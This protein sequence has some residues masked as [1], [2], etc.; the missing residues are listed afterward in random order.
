MS[1]E[2]S[3]SSG[4]IELKAFAAYQQAAFRRHDAELWL[5]HIG[6][7]GR[8]SDTLRVS[9]AHCTVKLVVAGQYTTGGTNY[10]D[11][12]EPFNKALIKVIL[13]DWARI[14]GAVVNLLREEERQLLVNAESEVS[15]AHAAIALAK[16]SPPSDT[17]NLDSSGREG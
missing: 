15:A 2:A 3:P 12:P 7:R 4:K 14:S 10:W 6:A 16:A 11:S 17:S 1:D 5:A 8:D 13:K 9:S